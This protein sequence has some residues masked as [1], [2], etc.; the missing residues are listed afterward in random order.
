[1]VNPGGRF[2]APETEPGPVGVGVWVEGAAG[3]TSTLPTK[4]AAAA[5]TTPP[6]KARPRS[7]RPALGDDDW[8]PGGRVD[9]ALMR[10]PLTGLDGRCSA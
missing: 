3:T 6:I 8:E 2:G 4:A 10:I 7:L 9:D 1:L 5:A